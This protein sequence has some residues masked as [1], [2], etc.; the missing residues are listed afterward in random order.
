M[1][2]D[3]RRIDASDSHSARLCISG[4]LRPRCPSLFLSFSY[5]FLLSLARSSFNEAG[6]GSIPVRHV[7]VN[8]NV[9]QDP[10]R[11]SQPR[12]RRHSRQT[13]A[14][15]AGERE[16]ER[17]AVSES[18]SC[19]GH[20]LTPSP[21]CGKS[22]ATISDTVGSGDQSCSWRPKTHSNRPPLPVRGNNKSRAIKR[23]GSDNAAT[24]DAPVALR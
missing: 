3:I 24:L 1:I 5:P 4:A 19:W 10:A 21:A 11:V 12:S 9:E 6:R 13:Y 15:M 8:V 16:K 14:P 7:N 23:L 20:S 22:V 2:R 18:H 17:R